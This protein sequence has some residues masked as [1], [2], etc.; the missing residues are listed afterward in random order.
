M[1]PKYRYTTGI[2]FFAQIVPTP[3]AIQFYTHIQLNFEISNTDISN[4]V[5]MFK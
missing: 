4:T 3:R 1:V 5:G 2:S